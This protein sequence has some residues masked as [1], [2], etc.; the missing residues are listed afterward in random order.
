MKCVSRYKQYKDDD[1][2]SII[3]K[4]RSGIIKPGK[5]SHLVKIDKDKKMNGK[6]FFNDGKNSKD[7]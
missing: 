4:I 6:E 3:L 2:D 7:E 1:L 5:Y